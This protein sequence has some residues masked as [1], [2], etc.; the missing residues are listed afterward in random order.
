MLRNGPDSWF[1]RTL[2][3]AGCGN[4]GTARTCVRQTS[5][6]DHAVWVVAMV[7][8]VRSSVD[9]PPTSIIE[10]AGE[11][12]SLLGPSRADELKR[13]ALARRP[14]PMP[15][16]SGEFSPVATKEEPSLYL[17]RAART[18]FALAC[19]GRVSR[20]ASVVSTR[21]RPTAAA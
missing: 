9:K 17:S 5:V 12:D 11:P 7:G 16:P 10:S 1:S 21:R 8:P 4:P 20:I 14:S 18:R 2:D 19:V 13:S 3:D 6:G 15:E